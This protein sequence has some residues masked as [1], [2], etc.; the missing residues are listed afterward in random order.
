M[1]ILEHELIFPENLDRSGTM[2]H[3][4]SLLPLKDGGVLCA[5]FGGT[6]EKNSDVRIW[7]VRKNR[8]GPWEAPR[9]IT[10]D[11][12]IAHW[13]PVL[14]RKLDGS[15]A[16]FYKVGKEITEWQTMV[17]YSTDEGHSFGS[18]QELVPGDVGGRG[19]VRNKIIRLYN[20][21]L[22]APASLEKKE[23]TAFVDFSSD[24][25]LTWEAS[26]AL[27]IG[28]EGEG[29][30]D[31]VRGIIQPTLWE[32]KPGRLHALLRSTE[33]LIYRADSDDGGLAWSVP[34]PTKLPNNNSGIDVVR[35]PDGRLVLVY[36]PVPINWGPRSPISV[37][38]SNNQGEDWDLVA[39]LET[40]HGE[41]SYP[42]VLAQ[43]NE[44]M[45]SYTW[46]RT[47]IAFWR[48][49]F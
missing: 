37:A 31:Q 48:L 36:N 9:P 24:D 30:S 21:K 10:E 29:N 34:Y 12:G 2:C 43:G 23:W 15:I 1:T 7:A 13:N 41:F 19:P 47:N 45:I 46:H 28:F 44:V 39:N 42:V 5:Y 32:S 38:V 4:T 35:L 26:P 27:R 17:R 40:G 33:G 18:A 8:Q 6:A 14:F 11:D 3:A 49:G 22:A 16:L 25:G 20:N